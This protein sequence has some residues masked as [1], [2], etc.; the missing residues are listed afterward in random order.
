LWG[1][2][3]NEKKIIAILVITLLIST[4]FPVSVSLNT[5]KLKT[6]SSIKSETIVGTE[7]QVVTILAPQSGNLSLFD[8]IAVLIPISRAIIIGPITFQS[9]TQPTLASV[10]YYLTDITGNLLSPDFPCRSIVL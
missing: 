9:W 7:I 1:K 10:V 6:E 3:E 8:S 2:I 5:N 4:A